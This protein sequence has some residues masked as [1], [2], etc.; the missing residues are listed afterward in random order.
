MR[1]YAFDIMENIPDKTVAG[2]KQ[3]VAK[4]HEEITKGHQ[5]IA[6]DHPAVASNKEANA[7]NDVRGPLSGFF[8]KKPRKPRWGQTETCSDPDKP[9]AQ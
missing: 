3:E 6:I 7:V 2:G 9:K 4:A 5:R 8:P 1:F